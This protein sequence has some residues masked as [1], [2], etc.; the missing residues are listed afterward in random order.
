MRPLKFD[1]IDCTKRS[2]VACATTSKRRAVV[3]CELLTRAT[4]RFHD[5]QARAQREAHACTSC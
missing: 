3:L 4:G 5:Y 1:I 2:G